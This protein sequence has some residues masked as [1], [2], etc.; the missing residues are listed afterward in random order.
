[1]L[2]FYYNPL[3]PNARRV[4]LTLL[5]K[6][7]PFEP[8]M[9]Q[10]TGDQ[11]QSEYLAI[12]PFHHIPVVV[13]NGLRLVES[14]AILDYLEAKYPTPSL[15]PRDPG[16]LATVRMVQFLTANEL[17][18]NVMPLIYAEEGSP[19]FEQARQQIDVT[20]TFMADLLGKRPWFGSSTLT[21]GDVV[22]GTVIP[23]LPWLEISLEPYPALQS[24]CDRLLARNAWRQT[25]LSPDDWQEFKRRVRI[26]AKRRQRSFTQAF[27]QPSSTNA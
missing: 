8:V 18:P 12:N 19:H 6:N 9:L 7:I 26:M 20:L 11:F 22:A 24:W 4:W 2:T 1:M 13:D 10:L 15:L 23:T 5:E 17:L 27:P 16:D 14:L 21:L 25:Q 3:S